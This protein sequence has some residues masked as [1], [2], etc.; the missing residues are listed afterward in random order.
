MGRR[1]KDGSG[2]SHERSAKARPM[3]FRR[4]HQAQLD[5]SALDRL[6]EL[7]G[8]IVALLPEQ[9]AAHEP[10]VLRV[11]EPEPIR[12]PEPARA[13]VVVRPEPGALLFVTTP[14]GYRLVEPGGGIPARGDRVQLAEGSFRVLRLG[15]SPLPGDRRRC[16][17][18][19]R[20]EP[21]HEARTP[22]G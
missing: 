16:A 14:S 7:V 10:E 9:P 1:A 4:R 3:W 11:P 20:E 13:P 8:R 21:Q 12:A 2:G 22:D 15:P 6:A 18:L 17:F 5:L 19:E